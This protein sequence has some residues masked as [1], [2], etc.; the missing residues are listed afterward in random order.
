[1]HSQQSGRTLSAFSRALAL[2]D[3]REDLCHTRRSRRS[4]RMHAPPAETTQADRSPSTE[5]TDCLPSA[6]SRPLRR[7]GRGTRPSKHQPASW[8]ATGAKPA[9]VHVS[10]PSAAQSPS[11]VQTTSRSR[12]GV[13]TCVFCSWLRQAC[14]T[15]GHAA[16]ARAPHPAQ[17]KRPRKRCAACRTALHTWAPCRRAPHPP[18]GRRRCTRPAATRTRTRPRRLTSS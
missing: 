4:A 1:M 2:L 7:R 8:S 17:K 18:P 3:A 16:A 10:E 5:N 15:G 9:S 13:S 14:A 12:H 6:A 11:R